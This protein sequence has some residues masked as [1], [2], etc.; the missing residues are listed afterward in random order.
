MPHRR[1]G[2]SGAD[3]GPGTRAYTNPVY[4]GYFADPFVWEHRGAYYAVGT[5]ALEAGG[6]T[7]P[8][9]SPG[10]AGPL[11][12]FPL[13]R[14]EDFVTWEWAGNAL[15]PPDPALGHTFWAPEVA[16]HE[17]TFYLYYSAGFEDRSHQLRVAT[18]ARPEGPYR[19]VGRALLEPEGCPF[20]IDPHPFRDDDGRWYL[21]YARDFLDTEAGFRAG[22]ALAARRLEEMTRLGG[23]ETVVLRAGFD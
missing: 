4:P 11:R 15:E 17:G 20:A 13:L 22:T 6:L 23:E 21:F 8:G 10:G 7:G 3:P 9:A 19:D 12:I 5:G 14:S 2:G 1:P 16:H 18:G